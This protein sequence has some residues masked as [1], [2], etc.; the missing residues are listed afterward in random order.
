[1]VVITSCRLLPLTDVAGNAK[2]MP[3]APR[4]RLVGPTTWSLEQ[5]ARFTAESISLE[6]GQ[7][8]SNREEA[9]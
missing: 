2:G 5:E 9:A 1:M 4:V 8:E 6:V 7:V 3:N